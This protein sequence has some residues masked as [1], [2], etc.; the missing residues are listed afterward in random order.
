MTTHSLATMLLV[1][2]IA[3]LSPPLADLA[4]RKAPVPLV[5]FEIVLGILVGPDVLGWAHDDDYVQALS[6][7]GLAMLFFM[8]GYEIDFD[9]LRGAPLNRA[10]LG[11][12]MSAV[13]GVSLGLL[14]APSAKSGVIVGIALSTT[15]LGT[16]LPVLR[17]AG[18]VGTPLGNVV[19]AVGAVGEFAPIIAMTLFLDGRKP[20]EAMVYLTAFALIAAAGVVIAVR[21]E[22]TAVHRLADITMETSGQFAVRLVIALLMAM[23]GATVAL[24]V[25]MLLGAFAAGVIMRILFHSGDPERAERITAKLEAIGFGF[26]IPV[27]FIETGIGYDLK[28]LTSN[29]ATVG[30]VPLFLGLFLVTRGLPS[31]LT[32]PEGTSSRGRR[33]IALYAATGLP[34]IVAI[35]AIG[36]ERGTLKSS[37]AAAMVGAG[38]LSVLLYPFLA[39]KVSGSTRAPQGWEEAAESW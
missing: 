13:L 18:E 2:V 14:L 9:R 6:Q 7:F 32:A 24:G 27:F 8:A 15:A 38:M 37:T 11:W 23:I 31:F 29:W 16:I 3:V 19:M 36:V 20:G 21:G 17:D 30:L 39:L 12:A 22:H 1:A 26:L 28:A 10:L 25:D 5:V 35:T 34:L 33:A 4:G